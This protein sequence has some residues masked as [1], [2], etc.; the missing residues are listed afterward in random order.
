[1]CIIVCHAIAH[2][3]AILVAGMCVILLRIEWI[4]NAH[5]RVLFSSL[6]ISSSRVVYIVYVS[7]F[8]SSRHICRNHARVIHYASS[9]H[10]ALSSQKNNNQIHQL[11]HPSDSAHCTVTIERIINPSLASALSRSCPNWRRRPPYQTPASR[12]HRRQT[13][14]SVWPDSAWWRRPRQ[15]HA[16]WRAQTV[17]SRPP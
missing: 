4:F 1:M 2:Q 12:P 13:D 8:I 11:I 5:S 14:S 3:L 7:V 15:T 6:I 16:K 9:S 17:S 10:S